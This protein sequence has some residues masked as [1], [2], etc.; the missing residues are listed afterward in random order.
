MVSLFKFFAS[1]RLAVFLL[2]SLALVFAAGTFIE[3]AFGTEAAKLLIYRS[4]WMSLLL[5]L[6]ALNVAAAA[7]DRLPWKR[8]HVGF[9][10]THAGILFILAGSLLTRAYGIEGQM[11]V[12]EG[13][14]VNRII[15]NE[16]VLQIFSE[17]GF[18]GTHPIPPRAFSWQGKEKLG[19]EGPNVWLLHYYPKSSR[20]EKIEES[21]KGS[22][23]LEVT[24]ENSWMK[25]NHWLLLDD[26]ERNHVLLGPAE[27]RFTRESLI[28]AKG[29]EGRG[30]LE[31]QFQDS[32]VKIEVPEK[33]PKTMKLEGTPYQVT[34]LQVLKDVVVDQER[35]LDRSK[36]WNN[37]ACELILEGK[38][39]KEKHTVFSNFPDFPTIHGMKPSET[40]ARIYY[41]RTGG[42]KGEGVKNELRFVWREGSLPLYQVRKG[43]EISQGILELGKDYATGWMDFKFRAGPY[44]PRAEVRTEFK[45]EPVNSQAEEHLSAIAIEVE[46]ARQRKSLWLGQ[47]DRETVVLGGRTLQVIYGLQ[48]LPIGFRIRLKDFRVENYPGTNRPASFESDI[49][50]KDDFSGTARDVTIRMNRPLKYH[51]FKIFQSGYQQPEGSPEVSVFTVAKDPGVPIKYVG[52]VVLISGILIMFYT[53]RFSR[54]PDEKVESSFIE[55]K[56][57]AALVR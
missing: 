15:L 7:L 45:E 48:T 9:V 10:I 24:L 55:K 12:Q 35:L 33:T 47:G 40:G 34:V 38:G 27:L 22:P 19:G 44:Y 26:P 14:T 51:G 28:Q 31:F 5:I 16:G 53:R 54:R 18:L 6:L 36:E 43:E 11:A 3:S 21:S 56:L 57:E 4:P 42:E 13:Q 41:R 1:L 50:L 2:A 49:I 23:A 29:P 39:L 30:F 20:R 46:Q 25:V 8:K 32:T 17:E 52:A 37:P